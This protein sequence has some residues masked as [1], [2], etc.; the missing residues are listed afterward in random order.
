MSLVRN[1]DICLIFLRRGIGEL[2]ELIN[3]VASINPEEV[4]AENET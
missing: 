1:G 3:F 4:L 2:C